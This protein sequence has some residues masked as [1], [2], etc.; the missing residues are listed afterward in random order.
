M[1]LQRNWYVKV[2]KSP[3]G[4]TVTHLC[5][6]R[7]VTALVCWRPLK[8]ILSYCTSSLYLGLGTP[9]VTAHQGTAEITGRFLARWHNAQLKG[10]KISTERFPLCCE[11]WREPFRVMPLG[12][13]HPGMDEMRKDEK[14]WFSSFIPI[15]KKKTSSISQRTHTHWLGI[16]S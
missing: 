10:N 7:F 13:F 14:L 4:S 15:P 3:F 2:L 9:L 12:I 11:I 6:A 8:S 16:F 1:K 5:L